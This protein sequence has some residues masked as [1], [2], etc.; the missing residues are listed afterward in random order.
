MCLLVCDVL[1]CALLC[2]VVLCCVDPNIVRCGCGWL[3]VGDVLMVM[4]SKYCEVP[5]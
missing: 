2:C 3:D 4:Y 1:C 5:I